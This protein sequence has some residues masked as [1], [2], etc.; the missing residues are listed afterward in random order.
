MR[1]IA[2]ACCDFLMVRA[3]R[4]AG[5]DVLRV[6]EISPR[7]TDIEVIDLALQE[8]RI[9]ITEDKDFGQLVYAHGRD[10]C[11]V[12]FLRYPATAR[13]EISRDI[14]RLVKKR[15][16]ELIGSF[17]VVQPGRIRIARN[18]L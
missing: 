10:N 16:D 8:A 12:I 14:V 3:L 7:A 4:K 13:K 2:D 6:S 1:F 9:L 18:P 5:Y 11:G 17:V 15:G